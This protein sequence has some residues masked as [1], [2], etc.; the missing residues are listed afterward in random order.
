M[1]KNLS[2]M[3]KTGQKGVKFATQIFDGVKAEEFVRLFELAKWIVMVSQFY[4][5]VKL[6][7]K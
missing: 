6:V 5:M 4:L 2:N 1:M 3:Q 7:K